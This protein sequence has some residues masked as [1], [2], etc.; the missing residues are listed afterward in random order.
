MKL[1][2]GCGFSSFV[3]LKPCFMAKGTEK[4]GLEVEKHPATELARRCAKTLSNVTLEKKF[5]D[6]QKAWLD[7]HPGID[8]D[9]E[10]AG[11]RFEESNKIEEEIFDGLTKRLRK[12]LPKRTKIDRGS[13]LYVDLKPVTFSIGTGA[14]KLHIDLSIDD[15]MAPAKMI[16][17]LQKRINLF[18]RLMA[19]GLKF[20]HSEGEGMNNILF[21]AFTP[22]YAFDH[23]DLDGIA[24][25]IKKIVEAIQ[26]SK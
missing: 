2:F 7:A 26:G 23:E 9:S 4:L 24:A 15:G 25:K 12:I 6:L 5:D 3:P 14:V 19:L 16:E 11:V 1:T 20:E 10:E 21:Q 8:P 18:P 22:N 13:T 17:I